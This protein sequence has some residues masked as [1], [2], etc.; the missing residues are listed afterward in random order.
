MGH[1]AI[2]V[3][4]E[5][6]PCE[7]GNG[8]SKDGECIIFAHMEKG[9][10]SHPMTPEGKPAPAMKPEGKPEEKKAPEK[11]PEKKTP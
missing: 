6:I 10:T 3:S 4:V 7:S 11:A 1:I 5:D 8:C 2:K 9:F